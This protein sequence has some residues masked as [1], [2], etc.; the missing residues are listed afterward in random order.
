MFCWF[1]ADIVCSMPLS[2]G[3]PKIYVTDIGRMDLKILSSQILRL[4]LLLLIFM[5][6]SYQLFLQVATSA[7]SPEFFFELTAFM[8]VVNIA[9]M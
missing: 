1:L 7:S 5:E 6:Q 9:V 4:K 3:T 2:I 8:T